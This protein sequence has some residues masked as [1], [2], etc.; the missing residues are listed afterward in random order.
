MTLYPVEFQSY[1]HPPFTEL[2]T[3]AKGSAPKPAG[4]L[5]TV[6]TV[7][8][9]LVVVVVVA[10]AAVAVAVAAELLLPRPLLVVAEVGGRAFGYVFVA[11]DVFV[12]GSG[13][14]P[15]HVHV[16]VSC[17]A[18]ELAAGL[19]DVFA[20]GW[21]GFAAFGVAVAV[22]VVAAAAAAEP[23]P[24]AAVELV[25]VGVSAADGDFEYV[26]GVG[27]VVAVIGE[28]VAETVA[29]DVVAGRESESTDVSVDEIEPVVAAAAVAVVDG[30]VAA[31]AAES[32]EEFDEV[33]SAAGYD[34]AVVAAAAVEQQPDVAHARH[35]VPVR[36]INEPPAH[37]TQPS[38]PRL[39]WGSRTSSR[40]HH[41]VD[42]AV[43][44]AVADGADGA[45]SDDDAVAA[46]AAEV[47]VP[48][49]AIDC[50]PAAAAVAGAA[51]AGDA[52]DGMRGVVDGTSES[53]ETPAAK[54]KKGTGKNNKHNK[55]R[56]TGQKKNEEPPAGRG[57]KEKRKG[58]GREEDTLGGLSSCLN[59][60]ACPGRLLVGV[61]FGLEELK[62]RDVLRYFFFFFSCW[63]QKSVKVRLLLKKYGVWLCFVV[64][65]AA[66]TLGSPS[67][68]LLCF[69]L[70]VVWLAVRL[71]CLFGASCVSGTAGEGRPRAQQRD[72][73]GE[74]SGSR[75]REATVIE[76]WMPVEGK[77]QNRSVSLGF[78]VLLLFFPSSLLFCATVGLFAFANE[79]PLVLYARREP[80]SLWSAR[81]GWLAGCLPGAGSG[82][83][84][85]L[86][87]PVGEVDVGGWRLR[88]RF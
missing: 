60:S 38:R 55:N 22:A 28:D 84:R 88:L 33:V 51:A 72:S 21:V 49:H 35:A 56:E 45:D 23:E 77:R 24:A 52:A 53:D 4:R 41:Y 36:P 9:V 40:L 75:A 46:A 2:V 27:D 83:G 11:A 20:G 65:S 6:V 13:A 44:A 54:A 68:F 1:S 62:L 87:W 3:L 50:G 76:R 74:R 66:S 57:K 5:K 29:V 58:R 82:S 12:F 70:P 79:G 15:A 85:L 17:V 71:A 39:G 8:V 14:A 59:L 10:A 47:S 43:A 73:E 26:V 48:A 78:F 42:A 61:S 69:F 80:L 32:V 31:A 34:A 67:V 86:E 25:V 81:A 37:A 64:S 30:A 18:A 63:R 19:G 7:E 16:A